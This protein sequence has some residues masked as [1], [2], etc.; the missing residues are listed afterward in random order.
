MNKQIEIKIKFSLKFEVERVLD[1]LKKLKWYRERGYNISL[2]ARISEIVMDGYEDV[3]LDTITDKLEDEFDRNE[4]QKLTNSIYAEWGKISDIL[5][6]NIEKNGLTTG[7]GLY[8]IIL[9]KY[10]VGGSYDPPSTIIINVNN[11]QPNE[12]CRT[13]IHEILHLNIESLIVKYHIGHWEKERIVDL[14]FSKI[15]PEISKMQK[16][17]QG[18]NIEKI[19]EIFNSNFPN[20]EEILK[21]TS[22]S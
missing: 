13:I 18:F 3:N 1:T 9:T 20:L 2:P 11:R 4:Y 15:M 14:I 8:K 5:E 19:D 12:I 21:K 6:N 22:K 7:F 17:P 10:G 16:L